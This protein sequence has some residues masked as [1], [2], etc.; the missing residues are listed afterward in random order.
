M[1]L[2]D[3]TGRRSREASSSRMLEQVL[4]GRTYESVG[5]DFGVSRTAVEKRVKGL[6]TRIARAT[7]IEGLNESSLNSGARLRARRDAVLEAL[8]RF[9]PEVVRTR[10][11]PRV[12]TREEMERGASLIKARR[13]TWNSY[14]SAPRISSWPRSAR[15]SAGP[16]W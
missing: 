3:S 14:P 9:D 5:S 1:I 8:Q 15:N 12:V 2:D 13:R 4:D 16:A 11:T 10:R 6:T 7:P